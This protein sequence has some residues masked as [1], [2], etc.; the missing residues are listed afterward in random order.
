MNKRLSFSFV[1]LYIFLCL[2][3][4]GSTI[5]MYLPPL[6]GL[7]FCYLQIL[8]TKSERSFFDLDYRWYFALFYLLFIEFC[9]NFYAFSAVLA[10]LVFHYYF[11]DIIKKN[12]KFD[13]VLTLVYCLSAYLLS[14]LFNALFC[15]FA[16]DDYQSLSFLYIYYILA[17]SLLAFVLFK[18]SL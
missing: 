10:F 11:A 3:Q 17:E 5:T 6:L 16:Q 4:L 9:H 15:Y 2:Y 1:C 12:L 8:L 7:Y 13:K 18:D 14:Y